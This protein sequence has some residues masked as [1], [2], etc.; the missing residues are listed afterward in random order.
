MPG[1][2]ILLVEDDRDVA[3]ILEHLLFDE[4]YGVDVAAKMGDAL[5]L[6]DAQRYALV[7]ADLQLPDGDGLAIAERAAAQGDEDRH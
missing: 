2:R 1:Q 4:G 6:L 5:L 7:I 3:R